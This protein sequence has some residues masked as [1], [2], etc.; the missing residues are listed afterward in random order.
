MDAKSE[1]EILYEQY[2]TMEDKVVE[3]DGVKYYKIIAKE[4]VP[5]RDGLVV[6][7]LPNSFIDSTKIRNV[8]DENGNTFALGNAARYSFK[9]MIPRWYLETVTIEVYDVHDID[10]IGQ[11]VAALKVSN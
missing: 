1:M 5:L 11:F 6:V 7:C 4:R 10:E 3:I 9:G 2:L 8:I